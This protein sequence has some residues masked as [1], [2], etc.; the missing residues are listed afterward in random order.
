M[1][2][3]VADWHW[4]LFVGPFDG[5]LVV[6]VRVSVGLERMLFDNFLPKLL[7]ILNIVG[8]GSVERLSLLLRLHFQS[9]GRGRSQYRNLVIV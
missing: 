2:A 3:R 1:L 5:V 4:D 8:F 9:A 6:F 7:L